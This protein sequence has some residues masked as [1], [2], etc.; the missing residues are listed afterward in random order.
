MLST[1]NHTFTGYTINRIRCVCVH[2]TNDYSLFLH[3]RVTC[4]WMTLL[5][6]RFFGHGFQ[7]YAWYTTE[8][9]LTWNSS[10]GNNKL[11]GGFI[12][13]C[14]AVCGLKSS[15]FNFKVRKL[16]SWSFASRYDF[17]NRFTR[18]SLIKSY[19]ANCILRARVETAL[20][21]NH[22]GM[23]QTKCNS[24]TI[25]GWYRSKFQSCCFANDMCA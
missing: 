19:C 24:I 20:A 15:V 14:R 17:W 8:I 7:L 9:T 16:K 13:L 3:D 10:N 4:I 22:F 5:R 18:L 21:W 2:C 23:T 25:S 11:K 1:L 6:I 12:W